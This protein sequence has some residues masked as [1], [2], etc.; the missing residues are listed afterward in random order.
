[1]GL[2]KDIAYPSSNDAPEKVR[3]YESKGLNETM[4]PMKEKEKS[5]YFTHPAPD[6]TNS[7]PHF[8]Q[9]ERKNEDFKKKRHH[10]RSNKN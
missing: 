5:H 7:Q 2:T 3:S 4:L 10:T 8:K 1:M 6:T 9:R